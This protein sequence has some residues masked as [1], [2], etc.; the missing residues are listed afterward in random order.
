GRSGATPTDFKTLGGVADADGAYDNAAKTCS[1]IDCHSN[2]PTP[3]W[4]G[5]GG[6][7]DTQAPGVSNL[8]V[9]GSAAPAIS[10]GTPSVTLTADASDSG[11]GNSAINA[12]EYFTPVEGAEG[13]GTPM[14]PSDGTW[15]STTEGV[16]GTVDTSSWTV[17]GSPYTLYVDARDAAGNWGPA[18][19]A[20]IQV[21]VNP[22]D[23]MEVTGS[24]GGTD[25][26]QGTENELVLTLDFMVTSGTQ[27]IIDRVQILGTKDPASTGNVYDDVSQV[28]VYLDDGDDLFETN[29]QDTIIGSGFLNT[30]DQVNI[31]VSDVTVNAGSPRKLFVT[32]DISGNATV[33]DLIGGQLT[34]VTTS[35]SDV[36][37]AMPSGYPI[38]A[39]PANTKN[40]TPAGGDTTPPDPI[41]ISAATGTNYRE[42]DLNWTAVGDDGAVGTAASYDIRYNTVLID[43]TN[44]STSTQVVGEPSPQ[45]S[46]SPESMTVTGLTGGTTYYFAIKA[47]DEIPN[48]GALSNS[49]SAVAQTDTIPPTFSGIASASDVGTGGAVNLTWAPATENEGSTPVTYRVYYN[50]GASITDWGTWQATTQSSTGYTVTGLTDNQEY[51][52][53]VRAADSVPNPDGNTATLTATPTAPTGGA[54]DRVFYLTPSNGVSLGFDST[55]YTPGCGGDGTAGTYLALL[56]EDSDPCASSSIASQVTNNATPLISG[57]FNTVVGPTNVTGKA[58]GNAMHFKDNR[59]GGGGNRSF[60]VDFLAYN[61]A[62]GVTTSL[63]GGVRVQCAALGRGADGGVQ[64]C[65]LSGI[66]GTIPSGQK[67]MIEIT[68]QDDGQVWFGASQ[69]MFVVNMTTV[70]NQNPNAFTVTAPTAGTESGNVPITWDQ[71]GDP[72]TDPVSYNVH[73]SIDGGGNYNYLIATGLAEGTVCSA[74]SCSTTWD[75]IAD[76]IGMAAI[77]SN[78]IVRV[79]AMDGQG[80]STPSTSATFSVDN[81]DT[82]APAAVSDLA[83]ATGGAGEINLTWTAVGD[84]NATGTASSYDIRYR[85]DAEVSEGNW[86]T[87]T[88]VDGEPAPQASGNPESMIVTGLTEG[89]LYYFGMKVSDEVPNTSAID[90]SSP[91]PSATAG[92]SAPVGDTTPPSVGSLL[93]DGSGSPSIPEGTTTVV[94]T[95]DA[96]D[97]ATGN[98]NIAAAEC[99][100]GTEGP[101]GSGVPMSASAPPFDSPTEGV[102]GTVD[103]SSWTVSGSPYTLYVDARDAAGNWGPAAAASIQVTVTAKDQFS[104]T[105]VAG[106]TESVEQGQNNVVVEKLTFTVDSGTDGVVEA[107][108][109]TG[110]K[111]TGTGNVYSDVSLVKIFDDTGT[112]SGSWDTSDAV[113]G[114]GVFNTSNVATIDVSDTTV[115]SGSP[116][117]MYVAYNIAVGATVDD[118]IGGN[119]TG[120][121]YPAFDNLTGTLPVVSGNTKT[122]IP[123]S[124]GGPIVCGDCHTI[125]PTSGSHAAHA[126]GVDSDYTDCHQCHTDNGGLDYS[127]T[128]AG[129]HNNGAVTFASG[130][131]DGVNAGGSA[132]GAYTCSS[133]CHQRERGGTTGTTWNNTTAP[134]T[135]NS[136]HYQEA[137]PASANNTGLGAL[138]LTHNAHFDASGSTLVCTDC[139]ADNSADTA[140][141]RTHMDNTGAND[142][143]VVQNKAAAS[144]D[145]GDI[146]AG[147]LNQG[148]DPDPGNPTCNNLACHN[149]SG[150][151]IA[152]GYQATWGGT[153][154]ACNF[155]HAD[156]ATGD[157]GT[158]SHTNHIG[159]ASGYVSCTDCHVDNGTNYGHLSRQVD[160][161]GGLTYDGDVTD[162]T[163][164]TWGSCT[165]GGCHDTD[166]DPAWGSSPTD[167]AVCHGSASADANNFVGNDKTPTAIMTGAEW[168]NYGHG[169]KGK[170]CTDC[171]DM[172]SPHDSTATLSGTNP[173][174]L[175]DQDGG[176][177][178]VQFSCSYNAAGCH[179]AGTTGPA[180]GLDISTFVTHSN[181]EM[182]TAGYTPQRTWPAWD[183][184]CVNCHDPHGDDANLS[185]VQRELYDK[186]SFT[187]PGGPPPAEPTEQV[188]LVFTD[189]VTGASAGGDSYGDLDA[190]FSSVCQE[191]HEAADHVSFKDG[192]S[193]ADTNHP[194]TGA[195]PGDCSSCH[196][197]DSAFMPKACDSCHA[198]PPATNAHDKH[199]NTVGLGCVSCHPNPGGGATHNENGV[200]DGTDYASRTL[201]DIRQEVDIAFDTFN[202]NG[203]Y[204]QAKGSRS[205]N[206]DGTCSSLYCHAGDTTVQGN[207]SQFP[208]ASQGTDTTPEWNNAATGACGTCHGATA[209]APPG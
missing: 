42:V 54:Q 8:L 142:G 192:T 177:G 161:T 93:V 159:Y 167:C 196:G 76:S 195:N 187:L 89:Q 136:C 191:C 69:L 16:T 28:K 118:V 120:V 153:N 47:G 15:N 94:L 88:A 206:G 148:A 32:Y 98:S 81:T 203:A 131:A 193:A 169:S 82:T 9:D 183:P 46:G 116:V 185:M 49:P 52:F 128:P 205:G 179:A 158:G 152:T 209:A 53:A 173:F 207:G 43:G 59:T 201:L 11:T 171:H 123:E 5:G 111:G 39:T 60:W 104:V 198:F 20:S 125:P 24:A 197:H 146:L 21:T 112:T 114:S 73:G 68:S 4:Y 110:T 92:V 96:D 38:P 34:Y 14:S 10:E 13:D 97:T 87:A 86:A 202:P 70:T 144:Q 204:S 137:S 149:P 30:S 164:A 132:P 37:T 143:A 102:T 66:T 127:T 85:T 208:A 74:G 51:A 56:N 139:H 155:C 23:Q 18:A 134:L 91:R 7:G 124:V 122:V 65:D 48:W 31:D 80:G 62:D 165:A 189:D 33:G 178:G 109:I 95:A 1:N 77:E 200:T 168:T 160:F 166:S 100:V 126:D 181:E 151:D 113:I 78:V 84:D 41:T 57:V 188:S 117:V 157:P 129:T 3:S 17:S 147:T 71:Q 156:P 106:T 107:L 61:P 40:I 79:T 190:P 180:T 67:L 172:A 150:T 2:V 141:P 58:S 184:A 108:Q 145:E 175:V 105:G 90:T 154:A 19:A 50:A 36:C 135:C 176:A 138:T 27:A 72:D 182:T 44:W 99:F 162:Y 186:A 55:N 6:G 63:T 64:D 133:S 140:A 103:T 45:S 194:S 35:A 130:I 22:K 25:C 163:N 119:L 170:A 83:A 101:P 115:T 29:G 26:P 121:I 199:V 174:R 75:T 12:A